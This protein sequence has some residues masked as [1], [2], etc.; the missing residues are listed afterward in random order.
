MHEATQPSRPEGSSFRPP[1]AV[2]TKN[3]AV[4]RRCV[5]LL[6]TLNHILQHLATHL[7]DAPLLAT[8]QRRP[9]SLDTHDNNAHHRFEPL[10]AATALSPPGCPSLHRPPPAH[11]RRFSACIAAFACTCLHLP[12]R[13]RRGPCSHHEP[14]HEPPRGARRQDRRVRPPIAPRAASQQR[15]PSLLPRHSTRHHHAP[16]EP[17]SPSLRERP[18]ALRPLALRP[19]HHRPG[20]ARPPRLPRLEPLARSDRADSP[21]RSRTQKG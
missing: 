9:Q 18:F 5:L 13:Q 10:I 19:R 8:H 7:C 6:S 1:R 15:R 16:L 12:H 14:R 11:F 2:A 3:G 21:T 20:S 4:W 17:L